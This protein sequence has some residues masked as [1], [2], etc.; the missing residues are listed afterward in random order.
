M[1]LPLFKKEIKANYKIFIIFILIISLYAG[2]IVAMYDP[3]LGKSLEMMAESMPELF[4]AFSMTNAGSSLIEFVTNYLFGFIMIIF[5]FVFML[6]MISRL[7]C[8]YIDKGSFA[9]LLATPRNRSQII[10]T[11]LLTVLLGVLLLI[12]YETVL[13]I[14][15]GKVMFNELVPIKEFLVLNCGL[16]GLHCF[17][18]TLVYLT[19]CSFNETKWSMGLGGGL[20]MVFILIQMLSQVSDKFDFLKYLTPLT[21]FD[22]NGLIELDLQA[23]MFAEVL[24]LLAFVFIIVAVKIFKKRDLSL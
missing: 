5:P 18:S 24:Y 2:I 3:E 1:I 17:F 4:A 12:V 8:R 20:G 16:F 7:I 23:I 11:Q 13:V 9:Y 22:T 15:C 14:V 21:L 10:L 19:A 6:I